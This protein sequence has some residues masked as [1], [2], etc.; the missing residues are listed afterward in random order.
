MGN[1]KPLN[2]TVSLFS[3]SLFRPGKRI[4]VTMTT[5]STAIGGQNKGG[6]FQSSSGSWNVSSESHYE[7]FAG[8]RNVN[9]FG[10]AMRKRSISV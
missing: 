9:K 7:L 4:V 5:E 3:L 6:N 10:T 8:A 2:W 1:D